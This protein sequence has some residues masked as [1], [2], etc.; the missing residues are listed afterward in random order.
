M[1]TTKSTEKQKFSILMPVI[2]AG[3]RGRAAWE[4][5]EGLT[6]LQALR[7][8]RCGVDGDQAEALAAL[9]VAS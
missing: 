2:N 5:G 9:A 7:V 4:A 3:G 8:D 6:L 1:I